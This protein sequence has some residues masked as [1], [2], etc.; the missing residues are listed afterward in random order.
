MSLYDLYLKYKP[1]IDKEIPT[2]QQTTYTKEFWKTWLCLVKHYTSL[3]PQITTDAL[4]ESRITADEF[5]EIIN[6][7]QPITWDR[8]LH[9]LNSSISQVFIL[10][11]TAASVKR[12]IALAKNTMVEKKTV[13]LV[14]QEDNRHVVRVYTRPNFPNRIYILT[15]R[16]VTQEFECKVMAIIT[17]LFD[18]ELPE[19]LLILAKGLVENNYDLL[20]IEFAKI[21][22]ALYEKELKELKRATDI[23]ILQSIPQIEI[24]IISNTIQRTKAS[25]TQREDELRHS[26]TVLQ[27]LNLKLL[28]LKTND[29]SYEDVL[30]FLEANKSIYKYN[31][32]Q[33]GNAIYLDVV[34]VSDL[35]L[36]DKDILQM[37]L[38]TDRTNCINKYKNIA[39]LFKEVFIDRNYTIKTYIESCIH[40]DRKE[41]LGFQ[42]NT[43]LHEQYY[44]QPHLMRFNCLG[45]HRGLLTKALS[46]C[47]IIGATSI[48]VSASQNLNFADTTVVEYFV[49]FIRKHPGIKSIQDNTTG[50]MIS[51]CNFKE[52]MESNNEANQNNVPTP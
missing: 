13:S 50:E 41:H 18:V 14:L 1:V 6:A 47:D 37:Y 27:E 48:L 36:I 23:A 17:K 44:P 43:R 28:G 42:Q 21:Y 51:Y 24:D 32:R 12:Q 38:N 2:P 29:N 25:I 4:L 30:D 22:D 7:N 45:G 40:I 5:K 35:V 20:E 9:G 34:I 10:Q 46:K 49:D 39:A 52:R 33:S 15:S 31:L 19:A 16:T 8:R 3:S 11:G 26:Y